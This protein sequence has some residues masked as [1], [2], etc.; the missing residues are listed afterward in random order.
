MNPK[1]HNL[2]PEQL[3]LKSFSRTL[4]EI[5][6]LLLILILVQLF[7]PGWI[8]ASSMP[9]I[10]ASAIFAGFVV[11]FR[12]VNLFTAEVRWKLAIETW[13]MILLISFVIWHT[14]KS[15][16]PLINLYLLV[17]VFSSI[18]LGRMVTLLEVGLITAFYLFCSH[19][20]LGPAFFTYSAFSNVMVNFAP[21]L[22]VAYV[23]SLLAADMSYTRSVVQQI[24]ETDELTGLLNMRAFHA[25]LAGH[26]RECE[27]DGTPFALMMIDADNLKYTNDRLGHE[28]GNRLILSVVTGIQSGLRSSDTIARY[29]GDEFI[30]LLPRATAEPAR[31]AGERVCRSVENTTFDAGGERVA[32]TVSIGFAVYPDMGTD[33]QVLISRADA[34]LYASK[35]AGRNRVTG[36]GD[37]ETEEFELLRAEA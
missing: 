36:Y 33:I 31:D 1:L 10:V 28:V 17:I 26:L 8:S 32:T 37:P 13:A 16:S 20:A 9:I 29:G 23:T 25:Q 24:S 30:A 12:Y 27:R 21:F 35:Q 7:V 15:E 4:A 2:V 3:E 18:T 11:L 5:E 19:E 22:V 34:A 14:G 6:W